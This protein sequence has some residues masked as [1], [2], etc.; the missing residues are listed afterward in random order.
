MR[1]HSC[2]YVHSSDKQPLCYAVC[3]F[4]ETIRVTPATYRI[5]HRLQKRQAGVTEEEKS[6]DVFKEPEVSAT[7][8][9]LV[10]GKYSCMNLRK[11]LAF[12]IKIEANVTEICPGLTP[13]RA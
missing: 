1:L 10:G 9:C 3:H 2:C 13:Y 5:A 8:I 6:N 4:E 11:D 7:K 12:V